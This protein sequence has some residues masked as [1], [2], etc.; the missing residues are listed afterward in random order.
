MGLSIEFEAESSDDAGRIA[1]V[2]EDAALTGLMG[3]VASIK[4]SAVSD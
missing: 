3:T 4:Q 2:I 1:D